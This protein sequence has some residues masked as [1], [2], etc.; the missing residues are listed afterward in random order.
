VSAP[1]LYTT[2][3]ILRPWRDD[4]AEPFAEMGRDPEVMAHF[5]SLLTREQSDATMARIRSHFE[6]EGFGFWAV[7]VPGVTAFAGFAGIGKPSFMPVVEIGWRLARAYWK[8]GYATE[9][10]IA[11]RDWGFSHLTMEEIVAFV[12]P[13]NVKSQAVMMRLGMR[14]DPSAD[15]E[16]PL[17]PVGHPLRPHWLFRLSR[18]GAA[19]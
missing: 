2:R 18:P 3:L 8:H 11:A 15:F 19:K 16:H 13:A 9:A 4:D 1:T 7:E 5:P 17:M 14:R 10:A 6:R 12:V